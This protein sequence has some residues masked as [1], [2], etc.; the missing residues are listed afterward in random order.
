MLSSLKAKLTPEFKC[1]LRNWLYAPYCVRDAVY[2]FIV[3]I[4]RVSGMELKGLPLIQQYERGSIVIGRDFKAVSRP[5]NNSIG[6]F[7]KVTMKTLCPGAK[8]R[9]GNNVGVSGV[10]IS[11]RLQV[12]IGDNVLLGSGVLITDNDAHPLQV[13]E[14]HIPGA[15]SLAPVFIEAGVFVGARS[16]ILKGVTLGEGCV[17]GAGSVVSK[18]VPP[19][20]I[21]AGNPA[22]IIRKLKPRGADAND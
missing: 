1:R 16:I 12:V 2:C 6:V 22:Q 14:R 21:V 13:D 7:Q 18:N 5:Q 19:Y 17:V 8:I 15:T 4:K 11:S 9:I 10:T 20:T 3:G